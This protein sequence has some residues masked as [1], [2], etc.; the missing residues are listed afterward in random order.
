MCTYM[1]IVA[2]AAVYVWHASVVNAAW[3][4]GERERDGGG[5]GSASSTRVLIRVEIRRRRNGWMW[6][7]VKCWKRIK[8][9]FL[10]R[11]HFLQVVF[12]ADKS[13]AFWKYL[14]SYL[15]FDKRA[16]CCPCRYFSV[17]NLSTYKGAWSSI[18]PSGKSSFNFR[19]G[20]W[21][22]MSR[23]WSLP[24]LLYEGRE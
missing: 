19:F 11:A 1:Y 24:S 22:L 23:K 7:E 14:F 6:D 2:L 17:R 9:R 20:E 13:A 8:F 3:R 21:K 5:G 12:Y 16:C 15:N 10:P 4:S 18:G